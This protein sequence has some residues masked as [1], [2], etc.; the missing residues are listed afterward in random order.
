[1]DGGWIFVVCFL[2]GK[3]LRQ[4]QWRFSM[5]CRQTVN[6]E[7]TNTADNCGNSWNVADFAMQTAPFTAVYQV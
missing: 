1:M 7:I 6:I 4:L 5:L 3:G 2:W